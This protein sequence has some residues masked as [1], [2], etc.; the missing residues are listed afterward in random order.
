LEQKL[1]ELGNERWE[2]FWMEKKEKEFLLF[3]KRPKLSYLQKIPQGQLFKL[4]N[5]ADGD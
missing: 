5:P 1:N 3:F 2:C 4:L